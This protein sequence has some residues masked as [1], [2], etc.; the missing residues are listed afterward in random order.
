MAGLSEG[1]HPGHDYLLHGGAGRLEVVARVELAGVLGEGLADRAG[2][3]QPEVGVDIDLPHAVLYPL[4]DLMHR[5]APRR[6]D[7]TAVPVDEVDELLR[8]ARGAVH[9]EV[10]RRQPLVD[11]LDD[12][13]RQ[14]LPVRLLGELVRPVARPDGDC[15][16]VH[17]RALDELDRL[18][19]LRQ[20]HLAA[21][22]VILDAAQSSELALDRHPPLVGHL[23]DLARH[24]NVVLE[25]RRGLGVLPE[26][27]VHHHAREAELY[28]TLARLGRVAVVL[29]EGYGDLGIDLGGR[30]HEMIEK[31]VVG[32]LP[33]PARGLDDG[34]R[35]GL[36][37]GLHYRLDLLQVVDVE[38]SD[39][40]AAA[41]RFVEEL[42]HRYEWHLNRSPFF[43]Y[44]PRAA[45][46]SVSP[47]R[48]TKNKGAPG[49]ALQN[50]VV[51]TPRRDP[52]R[53]CRRGLCNGRTSWGPW[54]SSRR[55]SRCTSARRQCPFPPVDPSPTTRWATPR[56]SPLPRR[57]RSCRWRRRGR[58]CPR[59]SEGA[60]Y[61]T[62]GRSP[63]PANRACAPLCR[64]WW[65]PPA[66]GRRS[67]PAWR[68]PRPAPQDRWSWT[69]SCRRD[70]AWGPSATCRWWPE[71][72][73]QAP[74]RPQPA[75]SSVLASA[76]PSSQ[77]RP[78][79][80][81]SLCPPRPR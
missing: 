28:G 19:R 31:T 20:V 76:L 57:C 80:P 16:G 55:S 72:A 44:P 49:S 64:C 5:H 69:R 7:L 43:V 35:V 42:A 10:G 58:S 50:A 9:D 12:V 48:N 25:V 78:S 40:V 56:R 52:P 47:A 2:G 46:I 39:T 53:P 15:Q 24:L 30:L 8:D 29:V 38:G 4:L 41:R 71:P 74:V 68:L 59:R 22:D 17:P 54:S 33:G 6:P 27:A 21:P 66:M 63:C 36:P 60:G 26:R 37:R 23:D 3:G 45:S 34:R 77:P 75:P 62:G 32:V 13:H 11:L 81:P 79:R 1:F 70:P 51:S 73:P 67:P 61:R 65:N 18:I 14:D